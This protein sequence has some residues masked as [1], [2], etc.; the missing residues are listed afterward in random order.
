MSAIEDLI[1]E[2]S[3]HYEAHYNDPE[4]DPPP[5]RRRS[6][7]AAPRLLTIRLSAAQ[8]ERVASAAEAND[9]PVSTLA[10]NALMSFVSAEGKPDLATQVESALRQILK[11]EL[12]RQ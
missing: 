11:P 9:L 5:A 6:D 4:T 3:A 8:Y 10:R 2:E 12:L 1:A 7:G